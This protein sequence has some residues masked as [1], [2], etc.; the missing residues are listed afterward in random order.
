SSQT[1]V[2]SAAICMGYDGILAND[3]AHWIDATTLRVPDTLA[4]NL[5]IAE[6]VHARLLAMFANVDLDAFDREV[7]A[8]AAEEAGPVLTEE[9]VA[10]VCYDAATRD[11]TGPSAAEEPEA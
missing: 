2:A 8:R 6:A 5:R 11:A 9:A 10:T 3:W 1:H 7:R 4:L